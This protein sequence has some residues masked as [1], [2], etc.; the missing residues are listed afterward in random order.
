M[1]KKKS[2]IM[3]IAI[4]A[5]L[6]VGAVGVFFLINRPEPVVERNLTD[7]EWYSEDADEFVI[8]TAQELYDLI[9]LSEYYNFEDQTI[10]LGA[11]IVLNE[12][13]AK[14]WGEKAPK[15]RWYPIERFAGRF[16]GKGHTISG[17]Y[18]RG[19]ETSMGL[20]ANTTKNCRIMNL[21]LINSYFEV[22]GPG[23]IG[24]IIANGCGT[25]DKLYSDAIVTG[26]H[27]NAGGI[28]GSAND[29]GTVS[30]TAKNTKITNCWFDGEVRMTSRT[31]RCAG[32]IVG[33]VSGGTLN[34]AHCL[35][36]GTISAESDDST[37]S[38]I[39]GIMGNLAYVNY[40][41][42]V[43][44]DDCLN[45]GKV[46]TK[47]TTAIGSIAGG[48]VKNTAWDIT[49]TYTTEQSCSQMCNYRQGA[50]TGGVP[51]MN[52]DFVTGK[53]W[54]RWTTLDYDTYWT[55][56]KDST[57]VLRCFADE[58]IDTSALTK[59]YDL[60]WY[61]EAF[62]D[63]TITTKEQLYGFALA[64]YSDTFV[65]KL[66]K[67]G[68]DI[69]VNEGKASDWAKGKNLP[70]E[71]WIPIGRLPAFQGIFDGQGYTISGL[72]GESALT[73]IGLFGYTG[74]KSEIKN[75]SVKN[76]YFKSTNKS[77][78]AIGGIAGRLE[79]KIDTTYSDAILSTT[80]CL[81]GG[82][83]GYKVTDSVSSMKNSWFAGT[84]HVIGE[85][86]SYSGGLMG[87]LLKGTIEMENCLF[88]G[89]ITIDGEKRSAGVGGFIGNI[90]A[91]TASIKGCLNDGEFV[92]TES[93]AM[94]TVGR[95][96]G[97]LAN[98]VNIHVT[99][100]DSYFTNKGFKPETFYYCSGKKPTIKGG[101][102]LKYEEMISGYNAYCTTGLDF[103]KYWSVVVN[104][105]GTPI[106]KSF[107]KK[108]PSVKG[109]A[110]TFDKSWYNPDKK[111]FELKDAN[112]LYGLLYLSNSNIDFQGVTITLAND[113]QV[114]EG[115]ATEWANGVNAP[116]SMYN[117]GAIGRHKAFLGTFD[118]QGHTISGLYGVTD[119]TYLGL[120]G[121][122]DVGGVIKNVRVTN[123]YFG[124]T[125]EN[126]A[127]IG[128]IVGR[129]DGNIHTAY[130]DAIIASVGALNGGIVGY[131]YNTDPEA[132]SSKVTNCWYDGTIY[133]NGDKAKLTGG[134]V[135]RVLD[136]KLS[137]NDCLFTGTIHVD[138]QKRSVEVG[139]FVGNIRRG[140]LVINSSMNDGEIHLTDSEDMYTTCRT[141]GQI[142][143]HEEVEVVMKNSYFTRKGDY[144][145]TFYYTAGD[146]A[147]ITGCAE[148]K[149]V[150][151][152]LG[153]D[154]YHATSLDF[155][156]YWTVVVN[157]DGTPIL[158]SFADTVPS[159]A[160]LE[161][162][163]DKSWYDEKATTFVLKDRKDLYGFAYLLNSKVDFKGKTITL[164]NDITVNTSG[165]AAEWAAGTAMPTYKWSP[166][167]KSVV[168]EGTFDGKGF[169]IS[170]LCGVADTT[171]MGLFGRCGTSS[172]I[173]N[174]YLKNSYFGSTVTGSAAIGSIAGRSEGDIA[175][176]YSDAIITSAGSLNG[177]IVGYHNNN[178][179]IKITNCWYAG[180]IHM[181][182][183]KSQYT[184]GIV[185]RNILGDLIID[186][187][188]FSGEIQVGGD[189]KR[190]A[191][192][193]G[194]VGRAT[195]GVT[196]TNSLN[197]GS[198]LITESEDGMNSTGRVIGEI[199][200]N[201]NTDVK[202]SNVYYTTVGYKPSTVWYRAASS[203]KTYLSKLEGTPIK[204]SE[205]N[206]LGDRA[207]FNTDLDFEKYWTTVVDDVTTT[208][209][210][211][212]GTPVLRGLTAVKNGVPQIPTYA[213]IG[214]YDKEPYT[215]KDKEDLYGLAYLVSMGV[216]FEG[217][218]IELDAK[219]SV[220]DLNEGKGTV[221]DWMAD[222]FDFAILEKWTPIGT[223]DY[224]FAGT[225]DGKN[226]TIRGMYI[227]ATEKGAGLFR[228][229][230]TDG[231]IQNLKIENSYITSTANYVGSVA[232]TTSGDIINVKSDAVI[233]TS[234]H[235]VG[236]IV[237]QIWSDTD[238]TVHISNC[239]YDG[240]MSVKWN[241]GGIT[242]LISCGEV[243][244][245]NC[246]SEGT[247]TKY[248]GN[249]HRW[250]AGLVGRT[251]RMEDKW[252]VNSSGGSATLILTMKTCLSTG[253]MEQSSD[254][255]LGSVIGEN[256]KATMTFTDV[257]ATNECY[258]YVASGAE[259]VAVA[260][261]KNNGS[262]TG[263]PVLLDEKDI[264]GES[265]YYSLK[266]FD[267][268]NVWTTVVDNVDT[269]DV[270]ETST[271]VLR[272]FATIRND[273]PTAPSE[274]VDINWY[275]IANDTYT[276]SDEADLY[277]F[278]YL[279]NRGITFKGKTIQL[280]KD[281][282][283]NVQKDVVA[284]CEANNTDDL[285]KWTPIGTTENKFAGTFDGMNHSIN[286][287]YINEDEVG[288][289]LF[290][291]IAAG[292]TIQNLK[293][294]NSYITSTA[295]YV[296]SVAG[297]TSGSIVNV[298]SEAKLVSNK[299]FIGGIV[300]QIWSDNSAKIN[301]SGCWYAGN[302]NVKRNAG[303]IVA[304]ISQG[305]VAITNCLNSGDI[306]YKVEG[307]KGPGRWVGG[308]IGRSMKVSEEWTATGDTTVTLNLVV[309]NCLNTGNIK[310]Y[311]FNARVG[312][313]IGENNKYV[314]PTFTN[315]YTTE[316]SYKYKVS[317]TELHTNTVG[318]DTE[319]NSVTIA[320]ITSVPESTIKVSA[321]NNVT[322]D[323]VLATLRSWGFDTEVWTIGTTE[324][325]K[326][327]LKQ[328]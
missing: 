296:G 1:N 18:G 92:L 4:V 293:I 266:K 6:L 102:E 56:T 254:V 37:K 281:M 307:T 23:S 321:T 65:G 295:N 24:S 2:I 310:D 327:V 155:T 165:T 159:V 227:N 9:V 60:S 144:P 313:V 267:F 291:A 108:S 320:G 162:Y 319:G 206:V 30:A 305:D 19:V 261:G 138:G 202:V 69:V 80:G 219:N 26:N 326:P 172:E 229:I 55:V 7:I 322:A 83:A 27:E 312:S 147:T 59:A 272:N 224:E 317:D 57:P 247:I 274:G 146:K 97:Q 196:I 249:A 10:K 287:M 201:K 166:I 216:T 301:I 286:G 292:S 306:Q 183:N 81:N 98:S 63:F 52:T 68:N 288:A 48:I 269:T 38:Y 161:K 112:D 120:F 104:E 251:I 289:G 88:T 226:Q 265:G 79:G 150:K 273:I 214:W 118:G 218:R 135:G 71:C 304:I 193:A 47:S 171:Y 241:A 176:V 271:P 244:M 158:K 50:M 256:N 39:G 230:A 34:I 173:K 212:T 302:M 32:G 189:K 89:T 298:K 203:D 31:G 280:A 124:S 156:T 149:E 16:D 11:D 185:G 243:E 99:I 141:I 110:K 17:V 107:A 190:S 169:T 278:A 215:I 213:D 204:L 117:W 22:D 323:D 70:N 67:L 86:A 316:E 187:C 208:E 255:R 195:Y 53:D 294:E 125:M 236:G 43:I 121:R 283:L 200:N 237:G 257:Y 179:T 157:E 276:L 180:T 105:D 134:I 82:I 44:M 300:G 45:V 12:G 90:A 139:G 5:F 285:N 246:L 222:G 207:Y 137:I 58:V 252:D 74:V 258:Q 263:Q 299:E 130:S 109:L 41:G 140:L 223:Q 177:G 238:N 64:S 182:G 318:R 153:Y 73:Y 15:V 123:T 220:I 66:V 29:D 233:A 314:T 126:S 113:I 205:K 106:L 210:D 142:T 36:S 197:S 234:N 181:Q 260:I 143:N 132:A 311:S 116:A 315:V 253:K 250:V 129:L 228:A 78:S 131:K 94:N 151:D 186:N 122:V 262:T 164:K 170:G 8:T 154:G 133:L 163:F 72:Y 221:S 54:Y 225:F 96:F 268:E 42:T 21:K 93:D 49:N 199:Q 174:L 194:F 309:T 259:P 77:S 127:A 95:V 40:S 25:F 152:I 324:G 3:A 188:L 33:C 297:S 28:I 75:V 20:F 87:R 284:L 35:N 264:L 211:E 114:H 84:I 198:I 103:S 328:Q 168:F 217:K 115:L 61:S 275:D 14:D 46:E 136:G 209:I 128:S 167:G 232:G 242:G 239:W 277:G 240:R 282:Y 175:N 270:D 13:N 76:S 325:S 303:G 111:T 184:G 290:R 192:T 148:A 62:Y 231:I 91:G 248:Q 51:M 245:T 101:A 235:M 145:D 279:S 119:V 191:C 308:L 178:T 85:K 160:G 100:E